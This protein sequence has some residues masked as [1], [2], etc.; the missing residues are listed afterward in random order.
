[1]EA[2]SGGCVPNSYMIR[3][4]TAKWN[5]MQEGGPEAEKQA[6]IGQAFFIMK[7]HSDCWCRACC[8]PAQP[9]LVKF[10]N[11]AGPYDRTGT[12]FLFFFVVVFRRSKSWYSVTTLSL[13]CHY[14]VT[15]LS[16][17]CHYSVTDTF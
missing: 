16:L 8:N 9:N 13:L 6:A 15:T 17:L 12:F 5:A 3:D 11:T 1:M 2:L 10:W 7:E 14:S 4:R